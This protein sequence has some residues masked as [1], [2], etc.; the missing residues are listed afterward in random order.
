MSFVVNTTHVTKEMLTTLSKKC[1]VK[2]ESQYNDTE[3][4][5]YA[6]SVTDEKVCIPLGLRNLFKGIASKSI[7]EM[8]LPYADFTFTKTLFSTETDPLGTGR[9]QDVVAAEAIAKLSSTGSVF[10][11]LPTNFGKSSISAYLAAWCQRKVLLICHVDVVNEQMAKTFETMTTAKVQH[12]SGKKLDPDAD[13]YVMGVLKA[14]SFSEEDLKDIGTVI[15]DEAHKATKTA[16]T[17]V[18][19]K[20]HPEYLI[21]MSA[22]FDGRSDGL[23]KLLIPYFGK[24]NDHIVRFTTKN[25][26]VTFIHTGIVPQQ[27]YEMRYVKGKRRQVINWNTMVNSLAYSKERQQMVIS[28]V[29]NHPD[30]KILVLVARTKERDALC[31][32]LKKRGIQA[33]T[34]GANKNNYSPDCRVLIAYLGKAGAG[35]SDASFN[36]LIVTMDMKDIRQAEGRMRC[37]DNII[38]DFV[39]DFHLLS[40]HAKKREEWYLKKGATVER[41]YLKN[42]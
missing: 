1:V 33:D 26:T 6:I 3:E 9:D 23:Y 7:S 5:H 29:E 12:V 20:V 22:T 24:Q 30:K 34:M 10:L 35:F 32:Q 36:V 19:L 31:K 39:D 2:T 15:Y 28:L 18:L 37:T 21:G 40:T 41:V 17:N 25:F 38:Y 4:E 8:K 42:I 16:C 14:S 11:S 27:D 13:V